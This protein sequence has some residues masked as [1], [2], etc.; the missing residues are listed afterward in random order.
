[1]LNINRSL[2]AVSGKCLGFFIAKASSIKI[3]LV[4]SEEGAPFSAA[5]LTYNVVKR[6]LLRIRMSF[7]ELA[8]SSGITS[9]SRLC[10]ATEDIPVFGG[11]QRIGR[12]D[13]CRSVVP[14]LS[15]PV[16]RK[17]VM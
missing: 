6:S 8:G 13:C 7:L 2:A 14:G 16:A 15:P 10:L 9:K 17:Q 4:Y 12:I 11:C 1:M 3:G 5:L